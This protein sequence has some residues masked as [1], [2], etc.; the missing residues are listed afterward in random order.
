[1]MIMNDFD[2]KEDDD[3]GNDNTL[4]SR[5]YFSL[6]GINKSTNNTEEYMPLSRE[7][8]LNGHVNPT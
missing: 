8:S 4:R 5:R 7:Q 1:M 6:L 2:K 3:D